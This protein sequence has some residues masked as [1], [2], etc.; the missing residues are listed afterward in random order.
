MMRHTKQFDWTRCAALGMLLLVAS[1]CNT[2]TSTT[3]SVLDQGYICSA[4]QAAG[5]QLVSGADSQQDSARIAVGKSQADAPSM[6]D[7][8][9]FWIVRVNMGQQ[10]SG[11]Y[12]L[13]LVSEQIEIS[14]DTARV[15]L[16]WLQ[17]Q[18]GSVQTQ[19][20][21]YPCIHLRMA[22]GNYTRLEIVDK[23]GVVRHHLDLQ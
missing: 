17:P 5:V 15:V 23:A 7:P 8:D 2:L 22:K 11:G 3:V 4:S 10:P 1:G 12:G 19:A 20:L 6:P 13:R 14:S 21:T 16:E 18:P 9:E